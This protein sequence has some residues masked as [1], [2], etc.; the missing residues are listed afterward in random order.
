[1]GVSP[2]N[3][4][5][6][7]LLDSAAAGDAAASAR[8]LP[9]IYADLR[10]LAA[11][12]LARTPPGNTLQPTA[13]VH[14]AYI[15]L[16]RSERPEGWDGRAHFFGA[17]AQAMREIL[18]AQARRKGA[19]KR[20]GEQRR[21]RLSGVGEPAGSGASVVDVLALN[22]ALERLEAKD[23]RKARLVMLRYFAGLD[24]AQAAEA[25]GVTERTA[26]RDWRFVK[27]WLRRELG[28][29]AGAEGRDDG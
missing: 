14:E 13:L 21:V 18:V 25:L 2:E 27:A 8:L 26:E 6:T 3:P 11:A 24:Q 12:R 16:V 10:R 7:V 1:M 9:L 22:E 29:G 19:L 15:S 4:D 20:G 5:V 28:A 23:P 17:A